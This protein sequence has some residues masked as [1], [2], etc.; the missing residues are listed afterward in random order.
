MYHLN[1]GKFIIEQLYL[2]NIL[3]QTG[4]QQRNNF[5]KIKL[6]KLKSLSLAKS[7][8]RGIKPS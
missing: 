7:G 4:P 5:R 2:H 3:K 1:F 8:L 6:F